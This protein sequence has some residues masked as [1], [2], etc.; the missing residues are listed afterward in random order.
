MFIQGREVLLEFLYDEKIKQ[1][2]FSSKKHAD[3]IK[4][5]GF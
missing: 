5:L 3:Q 2:S 1:M 4:N